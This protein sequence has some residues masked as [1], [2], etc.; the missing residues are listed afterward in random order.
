MDI[1]PTLG[2]AMVGVVNMLSTLFSTV[3]LTY[4][5]RKTL[6]TVLSFAMAAVL[7]GLGVTYIES[8]SIAELILIFVYIV[9]FEFSL[10][11]IVWIY[12]SETMTEKGVSLGGVTVW[13]FTIVMALIT[14]VLID[15]I[16]GYLF[17]IFGFLCFI[18]GLFSLAVVKETKGKSD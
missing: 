7:V 4:F 11:P 16:G 14:P 6:L 17:I 5:G 8:V 9:L 1:D 15:S 13:V 3:L 10:G 12:M 2:T 18:C